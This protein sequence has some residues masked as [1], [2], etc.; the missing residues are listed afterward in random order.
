VLLYGP[1]DVLPFRD[2]SGLSALRPMVEVGALLR[3][4]SSHPLSMTTTV[5]AFRVGADI[6]SG[7]LDQP[8]AVGRV[9]LGIRYGR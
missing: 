8:G 4:V 1:E 7:A 2:L 3:V 9:L 6:V 5:Q